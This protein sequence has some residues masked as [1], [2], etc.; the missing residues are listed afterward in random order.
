MRSQLR[1]RKCSYV[2]LIDRPADICELGQ[3]LST[4]SLDCDVVIIDRS[5]KPEFE[6][7]ACTLRWVGRHLHVPH[8]GGDII[9]TACAVA[10]C[11]K[12]IVA[13]DDVRYSPAAIARMCEL[14]AVYEAIDPRDYVDPLPWWSAIDAARL[15][16][17]RGIDSQPDHDTSFGFRKSA[18]RT[19][20][21]L[22]FAASDVFVR[23]RPHA[24]L[25]W[26]AER[27]QL[28]GEDFA[29]P[30]K[31]AFFLSLLP[32]L[33]LF[34]VAGG[35]QLAAGYAGAIAFTAFALAVRGRLGATSYFP[36]RLCLFAPLW[37]FERSVSTYWALFRK[38]AGA[39]YAHAG[40]TAERATRSAQETNR[41]ARTM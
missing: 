22:R 12:V 15:L 14:L 6:A 7:N 19:G 39:T 31:T 8:A 29:L 37:V 24:L 36:L 10:A 2:V 32:L 41:S 9:R 5:P 34:A 27:P 30:V 18:T 23:R 4:V 13:T 21:L 16:V 20:E 26:I 35:Y 17:H 40:L 3:Y 25:D 33:V 38:L 28:A 11:E 1:E